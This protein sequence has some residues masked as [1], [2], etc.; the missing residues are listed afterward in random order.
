M[1]HAMAQPADDCSL[2]LLIGSDVGCKVMSDVFHTTDLADTLPCMLAQ[3][4]L[5]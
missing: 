4:Y 2:S 1:W 3:I 5:K